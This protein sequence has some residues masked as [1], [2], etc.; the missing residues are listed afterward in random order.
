MPPSKP[1]AAYKNK[2][3]APV[4]ALTQSQQSIPELA[5][6]LVC[7]ACNHF[8][9]DRSRASFVSEASATGGYRAPDVDASRGQPL[10]AGTALPARSF[11]A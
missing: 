7:A 9:A 1:R 11:P 2:V 6:G 5:S 8:H 4:I 10:T 3:E